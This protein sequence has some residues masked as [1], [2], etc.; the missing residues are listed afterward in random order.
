MANNVEALR[1]WNKLDKMTQEKILTNVYCI[2]CQITTIIDYEVTSS[3]PDIVL[4]G[5]CKKCNHTVAR[6]V[7]NEWFN[8][9]S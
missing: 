2:N 6:L 1:K 7:E 5:K 4:K 9:K 8:Y 3:K